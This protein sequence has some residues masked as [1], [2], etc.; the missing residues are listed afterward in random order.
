L[1]PKKASVTSCF[2]KFSR[3]CAT[4]VK[5]DNSQSA[6][7]SQIEAENEKQK[8]PETVVFSILTKIKE[9]SLGGRRRHE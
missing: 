2:L 8:M 7:F 6:G 5:I 9:K 1:T 4:N 3:L